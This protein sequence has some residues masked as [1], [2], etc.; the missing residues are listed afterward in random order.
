MGL[1]TVPGEGF[2]GRLSA[3]PQEL[4]GAGPNGQIHG[5]RKRDFFKKDANRF[6]SLFV[7]VFFR[8]SRVFSFIANISAH[9]YL[10]IVIIVNHY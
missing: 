1:R 4:Q 3:R 6:L 10:L 5:L 9:D 2:Q 8:L 7:S